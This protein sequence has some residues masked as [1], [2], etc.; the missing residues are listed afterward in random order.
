[1]PRKTLIKKCAVCGRTI[2]SQFAKYCCDCALLVIHVNRAKLPRKAARRIYRY[3]RKH[4]YV[5][6]YTGMRL[7]VTDSHSPWYFVLDHWK[8]G[9]NRKVVLTSALIN[10]MKSDLTEREFWYMIRQLA[11]FKRLGTPVRKIRL[12]LWNREYI[13]GCEDI[14]VQVSCERKCCICGQPVY[15]YNAQFCRKCHLISRRIDESQLPLEA[16]KSLWDYVR[17]HGHV[18]YYTGMPLDFDDY[19]SAW[20]FTFEHVAPGDSTKVVLASALL[21]EMKSDLSED[22]FWYYIKQL[23]NYKRKHTGIRKRKLVYWYRLHPV[24]DALGAQML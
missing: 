19:R 9:D 8:P 13:K 15:F 12:S 18:C 24:K 4:G 16:A 10:G 22:E 5:C 6:Y 23:D 7:D 21:N 3:V 14:E 11:D 2:T 17:K 20:H 1:M